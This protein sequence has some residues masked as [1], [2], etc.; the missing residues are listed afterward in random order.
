MLNTVS[1]LD[2]AT[3]VATDG[4]IGEVVAV[5][6]D[7]TSWTIR[8]LVVNTGSWLS[9]RKVLIAPNAVSHAESPGKI[10]KVSLSQ[11]QVKNSPNIDTQKPVSRQHVALTRD[12]VENSPAYDALATITR[13]YENQLHESYAQPGY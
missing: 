11:H 6:F 12:Q 9:D 5:Y 3:I 4:A 10:L 13:D 1:Y 7:D 2:N 8:Y